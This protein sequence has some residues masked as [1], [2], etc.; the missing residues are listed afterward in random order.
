MIGAVSK[1]LPIREDTLKEAIA[2]SV[3]PKT[4]P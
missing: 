1:Y 3:P 2:R 4:V